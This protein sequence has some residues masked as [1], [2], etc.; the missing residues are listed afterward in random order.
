MKRLFACLFLGTL[1]I[2]LPLE[3]ALD[4]PIKKIP[5]GYQKTYSYEYGE[6]YITHYEKILPDGTDPYD[7]YE[8][9]LDKERKHIKS[10]KQKYI[11]HSQLEENK[12]ISKARIK[13]ISEPYIKNPDSITLSVVEPPKLTPFENQS[14]GKTE[15]R[16]AYLVIKKTKTL[17]IDAYDEMILGLDEY[18]KSAPEETEPESYVLK[19]ITWLKTWF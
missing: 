18:E 11:P 4:T 8:L 15:P 13:K 2:S 6:D 5:E 10:I 17:Y 14:I 16:Y 3:A 19:F 7:A 1:L 9:T 12:L